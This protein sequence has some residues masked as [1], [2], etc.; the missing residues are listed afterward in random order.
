MIHT[1]PPTSKTVLF[2]ILAYF[3]QLSRQIQ[4]QSAARSNRHR[5]GHTVHKLPDA[6]LRLSLNVANRWLRD[7]RNR[8]HDFRLYAVVAIVVAID[9]PYT[10]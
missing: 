1:I 5:I 3:A 9:V 2:H 4:Q 10:E 7:L 6:M 8:N